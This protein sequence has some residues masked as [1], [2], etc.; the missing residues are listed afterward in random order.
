MAQE[1]LYG[2][3]F[4]KQ[5]TYYLEQL[6]YYEQ[7]KRFRFNYASLI[8]G[9]FWFLYRKMYLEFFIIYAFYIIETTFENTILIRLIGYEQTK[10]V[11]FFVTIILLV[12]LGIIGNN[13]YIKKAKRTMRRAHAKFQDIEKQKSFLARK[14]GTTFIYVVLLVALYTCLIALR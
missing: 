7:G 14:G 5:K 10:L 13:L 8:F 9:I 6:N 11:N 4:Q 3:F 2:A 1:Q 12:I